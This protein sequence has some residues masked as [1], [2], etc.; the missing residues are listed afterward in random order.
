MNVTGKL[1]SSNLSISA[2]TWK[3][4][5]SNDIAIA[6]NAMLTTIR[7]WMDEIEVISILRR[8]RNKKTRRVINSPEF[9]YL[10]LQF[11]HI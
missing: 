4:E 8:C 9:F 3:V 1:G 5:P 6:P 11:D 2:T 7:F 10:V